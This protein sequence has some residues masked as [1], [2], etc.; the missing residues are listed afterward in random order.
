MLFML[1][2]AAFI[3]MLGVL[4]APERK[5]VWIYG[6]FFMLVEVCGAMWALMNIG[7]TSFGLFTLD[8]L[9]VSYFV[10]MSVMGGLCLWRSWRYLDVESLRHI[11]IY[12][13][14]FVLLN[15]A[16][17]GVY[18]SNNIAVGWIFLEATTLAT[19]GL[20]YHRRTNRSLEATWKYIFVSSVGIAIAYLGVLML[21]TVAHGAHGVD[22]S[23][24]GL[25]GVVAGGNVLYLKLAFLLIMVGYSTKMEIFPFF[26]VGIDA[27][28]SA[29]TPASAFISTAMAGGGFVSI[30]RVYKV[31]QGNAE[32]L[33]W[34][35]NLMVLVG[36][37]SIFVALIYMGRTGNFKRFF[38]FSTVENS[39]IVL[40][41]LGVAGMGVWAAVFHS[42]AHT[43]VKGVVYLQM[44]VVG[45]MY[46][47][48]RVGRI[49]GYYGRDPLGAMVLL[50]GV[51]AL[52]AVPGSLFFRSEFLIFWQMI[53]SG[54]W[55]LFVLV[56]V[57]LLGVVYW[58]LSRVLRVLWGGD[59][60]GNQLCKQDGTDRAFSWVLLGVMVVTIVMAVWV[61]GPLARL[62]DMIVL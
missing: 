21:S 45:R 49:G 2:I 60:C 38:A 29:P 15:V 25:A 8:A 53:Y 39:G 31:I 4:W 22:L 5:Y 59:S 33:G 10:L 52:A 37:L 23:Y 16:L 46:S 42:L 48:Y 19:A 18:F 61:D 1:L 47:N 55:W 57:M 12:V 14:S 35:Q 24:V 7:T 62:V 3:V 50:L 32:V 34:V 41:G 13:A 36:L 26:T 40:L 17:A 27:N 54:R 20:I 51:L 58:L 28:H 56:A 44:S 43:V 6:L 30:F 9:G 11:K